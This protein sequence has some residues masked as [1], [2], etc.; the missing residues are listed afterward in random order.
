V[1]PGSGTRQEVALRCRDGKDDIEVKFENVEKYLGAPAPCKIYVARSGATERPSLF[2]RLA[3]G[4]SG[5][6]TESEAKA[7]V[8]M[9]H[10]KVGFNSEGEL[11]RPTP[12]EEQATDEVVSSR[13]DAAMLQLKPLV[14]PDSI[15][16]VTI[17][18]IVNHKP[19]SAKS[20]LHMHKV[21][22]DDTDKKEKRVVPIIHVDTWEA[23]RKCMGSD[24]SAVPKPKSQKKMPAKKKA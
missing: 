5:T 11:L 4:G 21:K 15:V 16:Y 6:R 13:D 3:A 8:Q 7:N 23:K 1:Y 14:E 10:I 22:T 2:W 17:P 19:I 18:I 9:W 12:D 24:S 20:K